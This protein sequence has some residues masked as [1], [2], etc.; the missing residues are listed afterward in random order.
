MNC[1]ISKIVRLSAKNG[2]MMMP[3]KMGVL[4]IEAC[5][6]VFIIV[7]ARKIEC[8]GFKGIAGCNSGLFKGKFT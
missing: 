8:E 3:Q 7:W 4:M 5:L 1:F 6:A 2:E